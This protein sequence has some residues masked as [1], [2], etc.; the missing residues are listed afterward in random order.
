M[1]GYKKLAEQL[2]EHLPSDI[3]AQMPDDYKERWVDMAANEIRE[4]AKRNAE[5]IHRANEIVEPLMR[6][7]S[8][9]HNT[10]RLAV[11]ALR[12]IEVMTGE[13]FE[14]V[15]GD[16]PAWFHEH[17]DSQTDGSEVGSLTRIASAMGFE[18]DVGIDRF[19]QAVSFMGEASKLE[20]I[21]HF[22]P[23]LTERGIYE[24]AR[25]VCLIR[26]LNDAIK[27][28]SG[29]D[30]STP[31]RA[32]MVGLS[33]DGQRT[34]KE[35]LDVLGDGFEKKNGVTIHTAYQELYPMS[36]SREAV[37]SL[38]EEGIGPRWVERIEN[39]DHEDRREKE[40]LD[41]YMHMRSGP[42]HDFNPREIDHPRSKCTV[43]V[44]EPSH[45][46]PHVLED[47]RVDSVSLVSRCV[48]CGSKAFDRPGVHPHSGDLCLHIAANPPLST[49][50]VLEMPFEPCDCKIDP[51]ARQPRAKSFAVGDAHYHMD[52]EK[53]V[54][55]DLFFGALEAWRAK[56]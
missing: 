38:V 2:W 21:E 15:E 46:P 25:V 3:R 18:D 39:Y 33:E 51:D 47:V 55:W 45:K 8:D 12:F 6:P 29:C 10:G 11:A 41:R 36:L 7:A 9:E 43:K 17:A 44:V 4:C 42:R 27:Y 37:T 52:A 35:I 49:A 23:L 14:G 20:N 40:F 13:A 5:L 56:Q 53:I 24:P 28:T 34:V 30:E 22:L 26:D 32:A 1:D 54:R 31:G 48:L 16:L 19:F 50:T